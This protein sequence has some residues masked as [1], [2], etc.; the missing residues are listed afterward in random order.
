[1]NGEKGK[2]VTNQEEMKVHYPQFYKDL[3][4]CEHA[5]IFLWDNKVVATGELEFDSGEPG[6]LEVKMVEV[7]KK[8]KGYGRKFIDYL[9]NFEHVKEIW[10]E[11]V[12][13]AVPFW[14][15][16]GAVFD[17][18]DFETFIQTDDS[19]FSEDTL[20]SFQIPCEGVAQKIS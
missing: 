11:S 19:N 1:M 15:K 10:G 12:P 17:K 14:F 4:Y 18:G 20:F 3:Q 5:F 7:M 8:K 6:A 13:E 2:L 16:V 9:K